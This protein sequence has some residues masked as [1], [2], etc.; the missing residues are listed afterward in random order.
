[1]HGFIGCPI[2]T[3]FAMY[4]IENAMALDKIVIDRRGRNDMGEL[5]PKKETKKRIKAGGV[6]AQQLQ[7]HLPPGAMMEII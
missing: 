6:C 5:S 1:M 2:D 7:A 3:E 4:L